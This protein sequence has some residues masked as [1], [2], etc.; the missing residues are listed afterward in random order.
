MLYRRPN[1]AYWWVRF[2]DP[3][4]REIRQSTGTEDRKDAEEYEA[5]LKLERWRQVRMGDKPRRTWQEAVVRWIDETS[6]K[7]SHAKDLEH[8][9]W[10]DPHLGEMH[11]DEITRETLDKLATERRK[12]GASAATSNRVIAVVRAILRKAEREWEWIDRAPVPRMLPEAKRRVRWLTRDEADLLLSELP[13]HLAA[14]ARFSLATGLREQNVCRLRW[15]Q[16]D[17]TRR[18]AWLFGDEMKGGQSIA[19]PLN[20][21]AVAVIR[22]QIGK[23]LVRVFTYDGEPIARA[24]NHAWHKALKRA[25]I[26]DFRWHDLRHTWASWHVQAGTPLHVLQ[27]LG[28]WQSYEMVRR[29][30]HLSAGQLADHARAVEASRT[31]SGTPSKSVPGKCAVSR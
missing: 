29:Y 19:V 7:R 18:V 17:M 24:N 12:G 27:E 6:H 23:H 25:G 14:M 10:V 16:I 13:E 21:D 2:K 8:L 11:L 15:D 5:K 30:A 20:D 31:F 28:G 9:R 3:G 1:S 4:G 22:E 26:G